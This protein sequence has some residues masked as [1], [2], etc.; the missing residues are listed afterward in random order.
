MNN[1]LKYLRTDLGYSVRELADKL[2]IHYSLISRTELNNVKGI[3]EDI[4]NK[5]CNFF[6]VEPNYLLG[7]SNDGIICKCDKLD[8][9][10]V[11]TE[12]E[13]E[14]LGNA[15]FFNE[16]EGRVIT[17]SGL[18][19]LERMRTKEF[20]KDI[21]IVADNIMKKPIIKDI[22][23]LLPKLNDNQLEHILNTINLF[24]K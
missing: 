21:L 23:L 18:D 16:V 11:I 5:Y 6:R 7:F 10:I 3:K 14:A 22:L 15:I 17:K 24:I 9:T 1:K 19:E 2:E 4:I 8:T 12:E 20:G 13:Y